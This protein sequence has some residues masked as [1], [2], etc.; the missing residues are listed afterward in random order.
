MVVGKVAFPISARV[1]VVAFTERIASTTL[2]DVLVKITAT[3]SDVRTY[4]TIEARIL[5]WST[6][7]PN[8]FWNHCS[9]DMT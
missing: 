8:K 1:L 9:S 2:V 6:D 5:K 4:D 7:L 3:R